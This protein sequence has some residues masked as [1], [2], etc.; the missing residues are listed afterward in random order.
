MPRFLIFPDL[1]IANQVPHRLIN[2]LEEPLEDVE[3]VLVLYHFHGKEHV[4]SFP[5][6]GKVDADLWHVQ[7]KSLLMH[8]VWHTD[9][10][11]IKDWIDWTKQMVQFAYTWS[12]VG[13]PPSLRMCMESLCEQYTGHDF[14][15]LVAMCDG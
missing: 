15:E 7:V 8:P 6:R 1:T 13:V 10:E 14:E 4:Y 11:D 3:E 12:L 9:T 5:T 2:L